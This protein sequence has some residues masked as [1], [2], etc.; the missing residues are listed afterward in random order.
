M[1]QRISNR[2]KIL[3]TAQELFYSVG[4]QA[5]SVEAI[6]RES[7]VAKSN[8]YYHFPTKETLALV[9]LELRIAEYEAL[10]VHSLRNTT[11]TPSARLSRFFEHISQAQQQIQMGGCPFGNLVA[12]LPAHSRDTTQEKFRRRLSDLFRDI[13]EAMRECLT[14]GA[15]QGEFRTDISASEMAAFLVASVQGLLILAKAHRDIDSLVQGLSVAQRLLQ[16]A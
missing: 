7:G 6:L 10:V 2:E 14:E 5:T 13:E 3:R 12:S 11:L 9:V 15:M 16:V 4:Y 1:S 8:F